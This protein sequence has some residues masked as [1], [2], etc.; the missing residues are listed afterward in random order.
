MLQTLAMWCLDSS[1]EIRD[2]IK[3]CYKGSRQ[4]EDRNVTL[5][6]Q[7][8]GQDGD[9][10]RYWL[11]RG[12]DGT[13]FRV[14]RENDPVALEHKHYSEALREQ[15]ANGNVKSNGKTF[16]SDASVVD[17]NELNLLADTPAMEMSSNAWRSVAGNTAE[18]ERVAAR[19]NEDESRPAGVLSHKMLAAITILDRSEEVCKQAP[20]L[21]IGLTRS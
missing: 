21:T 16:A 1:D 4:P 18:V 17:G 15:K 12:V 9:R 8:W 19:L 14:Y 11:I 3:E 13:H 6:V 7:Q 2:M 20:L 10:R 5:A